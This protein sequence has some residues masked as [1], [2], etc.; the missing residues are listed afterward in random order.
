MYY[1]LSI[2]LRQARKLGL[3]LAVSGYY[4]EELE[5]VYWTTGSPIKKQFTAPTNIVLNED[6]NIE[7]AESVLESDIND[8]KTY[9]I[10]AWIGVV[11]Y[12][13]SRMADY[14]RSAACL[15]SSVSVVW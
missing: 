11:N 12:G 14:Y 3:K 9:L 2:N 13:I 6:D 5:D 15:N 4:P 7:E 8:L 10:T 1:Q